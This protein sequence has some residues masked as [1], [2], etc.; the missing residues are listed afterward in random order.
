MVTDR[1]PTGRSLSMPGGL[2]AGAL[3]AMAIT[4]AGTA[5]LAKLISDEIIPQS[6]TGYGIMV[7]LI[8]GS[9]A[10]AVISKNK[11]RRRK[12]LVCM[13]SAGVY[14]GLLLLMT[15]LFFG[16]QYSGVGETALLI[17]CG[18]SL[19][20]IMVPQRKAGRKPKKLKIRC[21]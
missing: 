2:A 11:I 17:L 6:G 10:G 16:G 20:L 1:K 5:I 21:C 15:A 18:A 4:L 13:A 19:G 3:A 7:M 8:L 12:L 14:F 9:W